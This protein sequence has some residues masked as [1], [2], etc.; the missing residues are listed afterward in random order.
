MKT[1]KALRGWRSFGTRAVAVL[2]T[3]LLATQMV[4]TPAFASGEY[5]T[6][7]EQENTITN[8]VNDVTM[9][10]A[11]ETTA[12]E[13]TEAEEATPQEEQQ[14]ADDSE[15]SQ[16]TQEQSAT[17]PAD[18]GSTEGA[19]SDSS[20]EVAS[21]TLDLADTAS[22]TYGEE[23]ITDDTD[24]LE[25]PANQELKFTASADEGFQI[26]SVKTVIDGTETELTADDATGEYA[27]PAD[28]VTDALA[29]KVA[30]S[31]VSEPNS[32]PVSNS[33]SGIQTFASRVA[34]GNSWEPIFHEGTLYSGSYYSGNLVIGKHCYENESQPIGEPTSVELDTKISYLPPLQ[35]VNVE[36]LKLDGYD[37]IGAYYDNTQISTFRIGNSGDLQFRA[38]SGGSWQNVSS[39]DQ[40]TFLY[41]KRGDYTVKWHVNGQVVETDYYNAGDTPVFNGNTSRTVSTSWGHNTFTTNNWATQ[42]NSQDYVS[43]NELPK[44]SGDADYY[45]VYTSKAFFYFVLPGC[46]NTSTEAKDYMY[47]GEGTVIVPDGFTGSTRWY[48]S[49]HDINALIID[50]ATDVA[51][52]EG[53]EKYY[54]GRNGRAKYNINWEYSVTWTT[55]SLGDNSVDYN[56]QVIPGYADKSMPHVDGAISILT[57]NQATASYQVTMPD[58]TTV[59]QSKVHDKNSSIPINSTVTDSGTFETDGYDY[60]ATISYGGQRY[61]FD[62]WYTDENYTHK[63]ADSVQLAKSMTFY[64]RYIA[65]T[66]TLTLDANG[67]AFDGGVTWSNKYAEG[68]IINLS[69]LDQPSYDGYELLGWSTSENG[70]VNVGNSYQMP[71][72]DTTLYAVWE[73][74]ASL[75]TPIHVKLLKGNTQISAPTNIDIDDWL[76]NDNN[77]RTQ[78]L[79]AV[80]DSDDSNLYEVTYKYETYDCADFKLTVNN[81]PAGYQVERPTQ[82]GSTTEGL[83]ECKIEG[84][85][86]NWELDNVPGGATVTVKLV[87]ITNNLSATGYSGV[88]DGDSHQV[89]VSNTIEGDVVK[90]KNAEGEEIENSFTNVSDS[91]TV[92][93]EVYRDGV[94]I[95]SDDVKVEI[96]AITVNGTIPDAS[97]AFDGTAALDGDD[98]VE[99]TPAG[100]LDK[101]AAD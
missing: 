3:A 4:G 34:D 82:S 96:T 98:S 38:T 47:S 52:R 35:E 36:D 16:A 29:V 76:D 17:D 78:E 12:D 28:Q 74:S 5:A 54:D 81:I 62:G 71:D 65:A 83:P 46:S 18:D 75:G 94:R 11:E 59:A 86:A 99:V 13:S 1:S 66:H 56:Y 30:A 27:V 63:A 85:G 55:L 40:I 77:P 57:D 68:D 26:E 14:P 93:V 43:M 90:C 91:Q 64:A 49:N 45:A 61:V 88:Y 84:S 48:N 32:A 100:V 79:E 15:E 51:I 21:V 101:D 41:E 25:V 67:G 8:D 50:E 22:I 72:E 87:P 58:D 39:V 24:P 70:P 97:K 23:T 7:S 60:Q 80:T 33:A 73:R 95:W 20:D 44:V 92:T 42:P 9:D 10:P 31:K 89:S 6:D 19:S 37:F 69:A 53:L 2:L